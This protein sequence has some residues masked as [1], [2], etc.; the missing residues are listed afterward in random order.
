[1]KVELCSP[2][3]TKRSKAV[4]EEAVKERAIR[5]VFKEH[6][7]IQVQVFEVCQASELFSGPGFMDIAPAKVEGA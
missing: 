4:F 2:R 6:D 3:G 7:S 1:M 5:A